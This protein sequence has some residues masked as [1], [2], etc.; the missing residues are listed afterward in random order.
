MNE[1][2]GRTNHLTRA[3]VIW[4]ITTAI[5]LGLLLVFG[6]Q[7]VSWK[8]LPPIA[9]ARASDIDQVLGLFTF[10]SIP[11]F[12][13]VVVFAFYSA[14]VWGSRN[15]PPAAGPTRL[16]TPKLQPIWMISSVVLVIFL[17]VYGLHFLSAVDAAPTGDVLQV[18]VTGEQWLWNYTYPQYGNIQGTTL[19]LPVNRP[20]EFT[21]V[22]IDVQHS[23][24]IPAMGIKEDA[25]PGETNHISVTPTAIGTYIVRCAELCGLYHAYMETPVK[26]VSEADFQAWVQQQPTPPAAPTSLISPDALPPV[27]A[28]R[29]ALALITGQTEG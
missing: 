27:A 13:L 5:G 3:L 9:S 2:A 11:V 7:F 21:V 14:I 23:F 22:S 18:T 24:W 4:V 28:N 8:V 16:V 15:R 12:T 6:P 26:V 19:V 29:N 20:V 25:V 10:L 1:N 17:Y